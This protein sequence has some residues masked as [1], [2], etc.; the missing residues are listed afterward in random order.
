MDAVAGSHLLQWRNVSSFDIRW[1][2]DSSIV[3][4][5]LIEQ[6]RRSL[7]QRPHLNIRRCV[8]AG[9]ALVDPP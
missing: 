4:R 3:E 1:K 6:E 9:F 8:T 7:Q 2:T 5:A